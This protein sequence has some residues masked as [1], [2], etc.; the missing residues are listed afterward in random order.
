MLIY[1]L[2]ICLQIADSLCVGQRS[3]DGLEERVILFLKMAAGDDV[4]PDLVRRLGS[5]I[6]SQLS[7]RLVYCT[8]APPV[9]GSCLLGARRCSSKME[10]WCSSMVGMW[11]G[12]WL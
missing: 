2:M 7:A 11:C 1:L 9:L 5:S 4:T 12:Q 8:Q 10:M 3:P 6:R